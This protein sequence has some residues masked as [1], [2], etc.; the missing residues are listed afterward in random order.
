MGHLIHLPDFR[1]PNGRPKW[2]VR[3]A[4]V[5]THRKRFFATSHIGRQMLL[6]DSLFLSDQTKRLMFF[7]T[8]YSTNKQIVFNI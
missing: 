1:L 7:E 8:L 2:G 4:I 5:P 6:V 3:D